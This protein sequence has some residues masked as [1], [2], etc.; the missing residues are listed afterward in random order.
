[1]EAAA[2]R[3][4]NRLVRRGPC[5]GVLAVAARSLAAILSAL[6]E[7]RRGAVVGDDPSHSFGILL[8]GAYPDWTG[9]AALRKAAI[10]SEVQ[11]R[12]GELLGRQTGG[13]MH[14]R[15]LPQ[16]VLKGRRA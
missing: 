3:S 2:G 6:D 11:G 16:G 1:M 4:V 9:A 7:V 10:G 12:Q 8:F 5:A 15:A 14:P 13:C